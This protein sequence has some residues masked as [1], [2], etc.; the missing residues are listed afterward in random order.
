M[1]L[2]VCVCVFVVVVVVAVVVVV[3]VVVAVVVV[4]LWSIWPE[5][6]SRT[7]LPRREIISKPNGSQNQEKGLRIDLARKHL[8]NTSSTKGNHR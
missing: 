5:N 3:V 2:C 1:F 8:Q 4:V 7:S 6:T